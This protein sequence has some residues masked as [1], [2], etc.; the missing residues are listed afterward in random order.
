MELSEGKKLS[1]GLEGMGAGAL[2]GERDLA[3]PLPLPL[4]PPLGTPDGTTGTIESREGVFSIRESKAEA[5]KEDCDGAS[6]KSIRNKL[7]K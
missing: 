6:E 7:A 1:L 5:E 2:A 3:E 4:G